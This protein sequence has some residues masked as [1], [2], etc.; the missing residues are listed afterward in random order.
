VG[1]AKT[2]GRN[3][4]CP[5]GSGKKYKHCHGRPKPPA[6]VL[7][8][9]PAK[10]DVDT[11]AQHHTSRDVEMGRPYGLIPMGVPALV[12][13]LRAHG[14]AVRG[15]SFPMEHKL[16]REFDL[17][18][19]LRTQGQARVVLIDL[20]WY[21]HCYGAISAANVAKEALPNAWV[22]LGGLSAS[23]F[24]R[25]ILERFASVDFIVRG[26]AEGPL[27]ALVQRCLAAPAS[28][29]PDVTDIDNLSYRAGGEVMENPIGYCAATEDLDGLDYADL[30]FL[31]HSREYF[32]HEYLVTD[33]PKARAALETDPFLGRWV[34]TARGCKYECSYCGGC[35]SAHRVLAGRDGIVPRSP[36]A[37][38]DEI[39]RLADAG[40]IQVSLS[41]DIAE[42]GDD[43][44]RTFFSLMRKR[45][46]KIGLY[47]ECFQMPSL[48][49]V[50]SF[51]RVAD[52][53]HSCLAFSP[54]SGSERVRRLNGKIFT[55]AELLNILDYLSM[56]D[57]F[58][59]I[60]FSLNLPGEND[61]TLTES[62]ELAQQM[63]E[64]YPASR[65]RILSSCHT[66]D[67]LS[68]MAVHPEKFAIDVGMRTFD[69]WYTYC[70]DTQLRDPAA[71]TEAHRGF[72]PSD[73]GTRELEKMADR[74]DA[75]RAG[76]EESWWPIPPGW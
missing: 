9:H 2:V 68:P 38:V 62:I 4:P 33:L 42:L 56:S 47:N 5:C 21:E 46:I 11:Y 18:R 66:L 52:L 15:I 1:I 7:Y 65:L 24:A 32:V 40:V 19:W 12:N 13:V 36:E 61:E 26:D 10:Q 74:W 43:Y 3:D 49:F 75:A 53:E 67:P 30:S 17:R 27:P 50:R 51:A 71:R 59:L 48:R 58:S 14:I 69:D 31:D 16:S 23:G 35:K 73:A 39:E 63:C 55:N 8:V 64:T 45:G 44:W 29:Q 72:V 22:V 34:A 28:E 20:H 25:E 76:H 54:L 57:V 37:V 41:Y 6:Q 70:R 60:Y